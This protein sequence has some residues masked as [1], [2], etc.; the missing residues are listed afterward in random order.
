[1][2]FFYQNV[3]YVLYKPIIVTDS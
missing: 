3:D 1:V 2:I